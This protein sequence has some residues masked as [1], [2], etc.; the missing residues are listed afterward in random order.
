[1][2]RFSKNLDFKIHDHVSDPDGNFLII[3]LSVEDNRI[4]LVNLYG[5][6]QDNLFFFFFF[7]EN[8]IN[9]AETLGNNNL[10]ICRDF[11]AVQGTILDF[12]NYK[13]TNNKKG[14]EKIIE[15]KMNYNLCNP[16]GEANPSLKRCTWRKSITFKTSSITLFS[17]M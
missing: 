7:F 4:T 1:M 3:G 9:I 14:H 15:I 2:P 12:F 13:T 5:P 17:Y 6:S 10:I 8:V 11:N 16:F